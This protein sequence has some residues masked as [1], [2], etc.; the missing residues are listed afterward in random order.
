[1]SL[2]Q[3]EGGSAGGGIGQLQP[4]KAQRLYLRIEKILCR[5]IGIG[6]GE[7]FVIAQQGTRG[8][9]ADADKGSISIDGAH[10][11]IAEPG[12]QGV[13]AVFYLYFGQ[14][15]QRPLLRQGNIQLVGRRF[16]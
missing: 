15:V 12:K 10:Q 2:V 9:G 13:L 14:I 16:P 11:F 8:A 7:C 4:G 6:F 5:Q 3:L 1:M